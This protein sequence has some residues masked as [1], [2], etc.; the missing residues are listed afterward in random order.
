MFTLARGMLN[1]DYY[2]F[3]SGLIGGVIDEIWIVSGYQLGRNESY[4]PRR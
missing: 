4:V 3:L 2:N 1:G